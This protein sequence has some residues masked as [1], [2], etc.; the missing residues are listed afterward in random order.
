T[1]CGGTTIS[2]GPVALASYSTPPETA[3]F[4]GAIF[5]DTTGTTK[6]VDLGV[7]CLYVG[8]GGNTA[9]APNANPDGPDTQFGIASCPGSTLNLQ[10]HPGLGAVAGNGNGFGGH[11]LA[12]DCSLAPFSTFH[13]TRT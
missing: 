13:C 5:S 6:I 7:S 1:S 9:S 8:G 10:G 4:S 3:G 2:P 11:P 12:V